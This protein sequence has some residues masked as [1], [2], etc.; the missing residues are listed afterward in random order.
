MKIPYKQWKL[1]KLGF[2]NNGLLFFTQHTLHTQRQ[3]NI[4]PQTV[5]NWHELLAALDSWIHMT[6]S[7]NHVSYLHVVNNIGKPLNCTHT[8]GIIGTGKSI[9]IKCM[10]WNVNQ[11][12][13]RAD[14]L[15]WKTDEAIS[16]H[17]PLTLSLPPQP[18]CENRFSP[19]LFPYG[20]QG[21]GDFQRQIERERD[22]WK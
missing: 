19:P 12:S 8:R 22:E 6:R 16:L 20:H 11:A 10:V 5:S 17:L 13:S 3:H 21:R 2:E 7:Q 1:G 14:I 15:A 9:Y 4:Y 18:D